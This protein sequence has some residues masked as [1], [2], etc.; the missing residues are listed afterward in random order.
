MSD[1]PTRA[2]A[3]LPLW[4]LAGVPEAARTFV[5]RH[6]AEVERHG[7]RLAGTPEATGELLQELWGELLTGGANGQ[8][9]RLEAA[10]DER[11]GRIAA[12]VRERLALAESQQG[13]LLGVF[14]SELREQLGRF[15]REP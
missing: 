15:L 9:P 8:P 5:E 6:R 3:L 12:L 1:D 13:S 11:V 14:Q 2:Q 7:R 4:G 10:R